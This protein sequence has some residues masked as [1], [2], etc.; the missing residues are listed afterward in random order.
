[1]LL[2]GFLILLKVCV[3]TAEEKESDIFDLEIDDPREHF[4][5]R[6]CRALVQQL[7]EVALL[8][9]K[10]SERSRDVAN[11]QDDGFM[12]RLNNYYAYETN[13]VY[14]AAL[15]DA[16]TYER[17]KCALG[18]AV[19]L[20]SIKYVKRTILDAKEAAAKARRF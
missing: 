9:N 13:K 1:M 2:L 5:A 4:R 19:L 16:A 10:A 20:R 14:E 6:L 3:S 8:A 11:R 7:R 15:F 17:L 12:Y 18:L